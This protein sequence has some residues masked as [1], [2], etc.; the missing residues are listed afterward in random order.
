MTALLNVNQ[1]TQLERLILITTES[2]NTNLQFVNMGVKL[3]LVEDFCG[4]E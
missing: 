3:L 4:S 2:T 1:G